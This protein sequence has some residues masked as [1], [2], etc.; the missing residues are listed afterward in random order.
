MKTMVHGKL[1]GFLT[2]SIVLLCAQILLW[3]V[4]AAEKEVT[5]DHITTDDGDL[6]IHPINHATFVMKWKEQTIYVDPVGDSNAFASFPAPG[7]ILITDIHGD[8][9]QPGTVAK[10]AKDKTVVIA[11]KAVADRLPTNAKSKA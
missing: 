7:L 5:G 9:L 11:P 2:C 4:C 1:V 3:P 6:I 8:H 10:L